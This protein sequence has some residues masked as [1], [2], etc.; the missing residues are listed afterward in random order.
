MLIA[1]I[2][3]YMAYDVFKQDLD[4][5]IVNERLMDSLDSSVITFLCSYMISKLRQKNIKPFLPQAQFFAV[6]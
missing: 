4:A 6:L 5:A 3:N 2:P 1:L